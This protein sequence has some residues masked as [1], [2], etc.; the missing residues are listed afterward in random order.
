M[1]GLLRLL[2]AALLSAAVSGFAVV[3]HSRALR[4]VNMASSTA[5]IP[6]TDLSDTAAAACVD[7]IKEDGTV[8]EDKMRECETLATEVFIAT[9]AQEGDVEHSY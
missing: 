7:V 8:D 5:S 2:L 6:L 1:P 9:A 4:R 3:P